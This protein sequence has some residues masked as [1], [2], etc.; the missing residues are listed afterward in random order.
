[1]ARDYKP[2]N[3]CCVLDSDLA[4]R[5]NFG[6]LMLQGVPGTL[7]CLCS[8]KWAKGRILEQEQ[9]WNALDNKWAKKKKASIS[10][11][12]SRREWQKYQQIVFSVPFSQLFLFPVCPSQLLRTITILVSSIF[13][14]Q[15]GRRWQENTFLDSFVTP[16][17]LRNQPTEHPLNSN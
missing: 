9:P 4:A 8:S 3:I 13:H 1:M 6:F 16:S 17:S 5:L 12:T 10:V 2:V 15:R 11:G 14:Y 7:P